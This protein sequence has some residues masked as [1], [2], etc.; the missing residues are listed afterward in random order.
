MH[1]QEPPPVAILEN[2]TAAGGDTLGRTIENFQPPLNRPNLANGGSESEG[3][4]VSTPKEEKM[5]IDEPG[6]GSGRVTRGEA[7]QF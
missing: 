6:S 5:D 2:L 1:G 7:A 4:E 3:E